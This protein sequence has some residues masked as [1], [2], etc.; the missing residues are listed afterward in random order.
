MLQLPFI[1]KGKRQIARKVKR[2][3]AKAK[4]GKGHDETGI[5]YT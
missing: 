2:A 5:Y 4:K 1:Y 3:F